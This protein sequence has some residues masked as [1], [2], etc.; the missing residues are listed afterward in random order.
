LEKGKD[1][2]FNGDIKVLYEK[3]DTI[4]K[5]LDNMAESWNK[6]CDWS[7]KVTESGLGRLSKVEERTETLKYFVFLA[8]GSAITGILLKL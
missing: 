4:E 8:I 1:T 3:C 6:H 5:K 7:T 2:P